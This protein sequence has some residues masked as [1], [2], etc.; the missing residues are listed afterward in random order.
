[1]TSKIGF[2]NKKFLQDQLSHILKRVKQFEGKLYLEVGGKI[3]YD[4]HASRVLPGFEPT[5]KMQLLQ[6]LQDKADIVLCIYADDIQGRFVRGDFGISSDLYL[7]KMIDDF[8]EWDV[9]VS[10]VV[11]TRFTGQPS[12]EVFKRK[13]ERRG[14]KV[15]THGIIDDYPN[16]VDKIVSDE[17]FGANSYIET[18][19]RLVIVTAPCA[20]SGKLST[21]LSQLYHDYKK[22]M[23]SGYAKLET[24]PVWTLPLKH[25]V[26]MAY[27][28][29][30]ADIGDKNLIDPFHL[31]A[32]QQSAVNYNRDVE[33]FPILKKI[34]QKISNNN[35]AIYK[36]PT[37][38]GVNRVGFAITDDEVI[39]EA[40]KQE[41]VRRFFRHSCEYAKGLCEEETVERVKKLMEELS[42]MPEYRKAVVPARKA[43]EEAKQK[44]KG[45]KG[46]Y[47][48]AAIELK[49]G[50][51]I[52]GK[53]SPLL[54]A[55]SSLFL[56]TIKT[57]SNIPDE[58]HLL[59]PKT[60]EYVGKFKQ[61]I[62]G[63]KN[64][65]LNLDETLIALSIGSSSNPTIELAMGKIG[66]LKDCEVHLTHIAK[67]GDENAWRKL[68]VRLTNDP[69]FS[70]SNLF[71]A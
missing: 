23:K 21:C 50:R 42:I 65:S 63:D 67:P 29:S 49:D 38:M 17:G 51:I 32:Y 45:N 43:A 22:G 16:A 48:G 54:H 56:N 39:K 13:L 64:I 3:I 24:F 14:I 58:I 25:P 62:S 35:T 36:S 27:E 70:S 40:S 10:A 7:L 31:E 59:S 5:V 12:A 71:E 4:M 57:L 60:I 15:Y 8:R 19:N 47:S 68:Q 69:I 41:I 18:K 11:I 30:T 66:D 37:D 33:I 20:N 2:D 34:L 55:S 46:V 44:N 9:K 61:I 26:N 28:A 1:M 52:T 53:N 6:R